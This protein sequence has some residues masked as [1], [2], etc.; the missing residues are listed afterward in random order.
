MLKN[1][2][3]HRNGIL[4]QIS[5]STFST[6]VTSKFFFP[7]TL[8]FRSVLAPL[9]SQAAADA[10]LWDLLIYSRRPL[11][12]S[13]E[14]KVEKSK[15]RA[16]HFVACRDFQR[17]A[18]SGVD[19]AVKNVSSQQRNIKVNGGR[20]E[21]SNSVTTGTGTTPQASQYLLRRLRKTPSTVAEE[22]F[23]DCSDCAIEFDINTN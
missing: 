15:S 21:V 22:E 13:C 19:S 7:F 14:C 3:W 5:S 11:K 4:K 2:R 8:K 12:T 16:Y 6:T 23:C 9:S 1:L 20:E 17:L 18:F 10:S